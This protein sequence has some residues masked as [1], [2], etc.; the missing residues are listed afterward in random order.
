MKSSLFSRICA[1]HAITLGSIAAYVQFTPACSFAQSFFKGLGDLPGGDFYS[2]A[3]GVSGDGSVVVG[4][5]KSANGTEAFRWTESTG[6][7]GLGDLPGGDFS[8]YA[9]SVSEDGSVV[10]GTGSSANGSEAF[11]W[12]WMGGMSGLGGLPGGYFLSEA[13]DVS[14]DGSAV[15][16][17]SVSSKG[18]ESFRWTEATGMV[19]LGD[20]P[21]GSLDSLA[22]GVSGDGSVVVGT[23][24]SVNGTEAFRWTEATGM[25]GLGDLPGGSFNSVAL[26]ISGDSSVAVGFGSSANGYEAFRWTESTGMVGLGDLLGGDFYSYA[27]SV[28]GDS[29]VAV[30]YSSSANGYEAF[31]WDSQHGMQKVADWLTANGVSI[32]PG[33]VLEFATDVTVYKGYAIVV[34]HGWNP[35]GYHEAWIAKAPIGGVLLEPEEFLIVRGELVQGGLDDLLLSDDN[36]LF[37]K[38]PRSKGVTGVQIM[39][40]VKSHF[41]GSSVTQLMFI[42]ES[43]SSEGGANQK[44]L[45]KNYQTGT[46]EEVDSRTATYTDST[47]QVT[48]STNPSR[49]VHPQTG[50]VHARIVWTKTGFVPA[51]WMTATD[52]VQWQVWGQ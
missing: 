22:Y 32:P 2:N 20:L 44:I 13:F 52:F 31:I 29:F 27:L 25:V 17:Y 7:V 11:R 33:W 6:M 40:D 36:K 28:S 51:N 38:R 43:A 18:F 14:G 9:L 39:L 26:G 35:S 23:G 15:V 45:F 21:G 1:F 4:S 41:E 30:G 42:L 48:I 19:G 3:F 16:G 49:F 46:F 50:E 12:T 5:G 37:I 24:S 10:V 8:S 47:A 34:G